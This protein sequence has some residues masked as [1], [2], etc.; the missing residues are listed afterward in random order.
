MKHPTL[1]VN[2]AGFPRPVGL[3][4]PRFEHDACGVALVA[5]LSGEANHAVVENAIQ[6]LTNLEHRGAI[7][8]DAKTGDGAGVMVRLPDAFLRRICSDEGLL[9]P[10]PGEYA[11]GI[12]FLPTQEF[13]AARCARALEGAVAA[14]GCE[15]LWWRDTPISEDAVGAQAQ[16]TMPRIRHVI[17]SRGKVPAE[18]F[19]RKLY[20]I[21]RLAEKAAAGFEDVDASQFYVCSLS[22]RTM[23]YKGLM[24]ASQLNTFYPDLMAAD[25]SSPFALVHQRYSTN[26]LPMWA[27]AQPFRFVAHNGEINALRGNINRMKAREAALHSGLLGADIEKLKPVIQEWGSDS[28]IFDNVLELL[29][30]AGRSLPHALMMMVPEPWG[31]KYAM[32][33]DRRA[34]YEYHSA[35]M[36]PWDGPA[37]MMFADGR[38]VGATLDR[39]GLRPA[40]YT[41]TSDGMIVVASETGVLDL[42]PERIVRRGRLAP[43]RMLLIDLHEKRIVP[44]SE[45]KSRVSRQKPYRHWL[46]QNRV[47]LKG[48]FQP[49]VEPREPDDQLLRAQHL[50]GYTAEDI[51]D[52]ILPM[53]SKGQEP[54]GSMGNDVN[55]PVLSERPQLLFSYFKQNFA[56]VTN[57]PIDPLRE[58][59]VMSLANWAGHERNLLEETPEHCRMLRL[60]QPILTPADMRRLR[61]S[62]LPELADRD[63][64]MLFDSRGGGAALREALERMCAMAVEAIENGAHLLLLTDRDAGPDQA[65]IPSLLAVSALHQHLI[66]KGLR[67]RAGVMAECGDA[68]EVMHFAL[69]IGFGANGVC[70]RV[71]IATIRALAED[72]LIEGMDDPEEALD[73]YITAIRKG[74]LKTFSRM[75][76]STLQSFAG[77]QIFEAIGLDR[78]LVREHFAGSVSR[79]GGIGLEELAREVELR[80]LRAWPEHG[81]PDPLLDPGGVYHLRLG[82]EKHGWTPD[83]VYKLQQAVRTNDYAVF[84]EYSALVDDQSRDRKTLRGLLKFRPAQAIPLDEVEPVENIVRRFVTAAMS[85]GSISLETHETIALALN[86]I[87][88]RSNSGEGGEDPTRYHPAPDGSSRRSSIKQVASGRFGVTTEYLINA[89]ELQ[90]KMAQ[91]AKPGEGGQLPGHKV[92]E[93]IARV[94]HTTPFVTLISPPPHHDIY[95]IEDLAQLIHD[96][97]TVNPRAFVSVKLVS[98]AGVGT[99]AS[100][101]AK[102]NADLVLISGHDGGTGAS[103]WTSIMHTGTPWELGLAEAHQSLIHNGL[104]DRIRVQTDG[105]LRTGRDLAIAALLGAEEFGF[106]TA[107]LVA[108]GCIMMRKCH[109][110]TCPVGVATQDPELRKRF[111]GLPVHAERF[112]LFIAAEMREHM[113]RLGFRTVEEMVGRVDHLMYSPPEDHWKA[114]SLDLAPLLIPLHPG[115]GRAI[116]CT[117]K[118]PSPAAAPLD[119]DLIASA[120]PALDHRT[121]VRI[122]RPVRNV[123]RAVGGRLSG[124]IARRY[125]AKGLPPETIRVSLRGSAGQSLGAFL[126][127]GVFIEVEG[128]ANDYVG[129]GMCGGRIAIRPPSESRVIS[130]EAIIA[131]NTALYG[132]TGGELY[133]CGGAGMRFAVRNSGARAVVEGLGDHGCEYMTGGMVVVL[134]ETGYNFAAGMSGGVAYVYDETEMFDTRCNLDTVDLETVWTRQDQETLRRMLENHHQFTGSKRAA[135]ILNNWETHLPRFVKVMPIEYRK[136]MERMKMQEEFEASAVSA[137][138]EVFHG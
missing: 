109:L 47:D 9:L 24:S 83:V 130:H 26:T 37:A 104:R 1:P 59:L 16:R 87:G 122:Q 51:T 63:I 35:M 12:V 134:G 10:P 91:G 105:Q 93:D 30:A 96:L 92:T 106:G 136:V 123:H 57:P 77:S 15:V 89:D 50:F 69:L 17:I 8:G 43:G 79:L 41:V 66:R 25:F 120:K 55:L 119:E 44:N 36:E 39:N 102:A 117:R 103:P 86:R 107:I 58:E 75:G 114:R 61:N 33:A 110:N 38:Y 52:I 31:E 54:V 113:A 133:L 18:A 81:D 42:Q 4:D 124:E 131:G 45:L 125:G 11:A 21:R 82:G 76:I 6:A 22:S 126:M 129:K 73:L 80:R 97:K 112:L 53:A 68:R 90:I 40:R 99:I 62:R 88:G 138:E 13:V 70:P 34:F 72:G 137:T 28:A 23:V 127:P 19:E 27:L 56:Q 3:Y 64:P 74:L 100:G 71:A 49:G 132:A 118:E 5:Q 94:R 108:L 111:T 95:S 101:V 135:N 46:Q 20:V 65:P 116:H 60:N 48:L 29:T 121:P 67:H 14:E 84:K 115:E 85:Y 2:A 98:E 128:D 7:G 78:N 32:S